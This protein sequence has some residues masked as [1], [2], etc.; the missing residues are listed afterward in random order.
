MSP[1]TCTEFVNSDMCEDT[2]NFGFSL[3]D[4]CVIDTLMKYNNCPELYDTKMFDSILN[5]MYII[6][7]PFCK[8]SYEEHSFF[9]YLANGDVDLDASPGWPFSQ[10]FNTKE[11][12]FSCVEAVNLMQLIPYYEKDYVYTSIPKKEIKSR[13]TTAGKKKPVRQ[14]CGCPVDKLFH[15][16]PMVH[17]FNK[18]IEVKG[19]GLPFFLGTTFRGDDL[20]NYLNLFD[21]FSRGISTDRTAHD[22]TVASDRHRFVCE[23]RKKFLPRS[24]H[25]KLDFFYDR[26]ASKHIIDTDGA[27][28]HVNHGMAS[29]HPCTAHDN[30]I[31]VYADAIYMLR[32]FGF[33]FADI[34][35]NF[36]FA[37][38]GDDCNIFIRDGWQCPITPV[39][40]REWH[41]Q[42][43]IIIK[44]PDEWRPS[45]FL[46]FLSR[47]PLLIG[48]RV[49]VSQERHPKFWA[50]GQLSDF[51]LG[52]LDRFLK[53]VQL[54]NAS[55]GTTTFR[56]FDLLCDHLV[57]RLKPM[58][59]SEARYIA[60]IKMLV[61]EDVVLLAN[62]TR[63]NHGM[64]FLKSR[65]PLNF[66]MNGN[67]EVIIKNAPAKNKKRNNNRRSNRNNQSRRGRGN[68]RG[69]NRQVQRG[70]R[71]QYQKKI[72]SKASNRV[73]GGMEEKAVLAVSRTLNTYFTGGQNKLSLRGRDFL[74]VINGQ[75]SADSITIG[76]TYWLN[77]GNASAFV[78]CA[79][80][81]GNYVR[82]NFKHI[83][84]IYAPSCPSTTTGSVVMYADTDPQEADTNNIAQALN[85]Q[86]VVSGV[87]WAEKGLILDLTPQL[88]K[89]TPK[90]F[91]CKTYSQLQVLD[92]A[93]AWADLRQMIP[94]YVIVGT[95]GAAANNTQFGNLYVEYEFEL[96][97]FLPSV[98]DTALYVMN[99][100]DLSTGIQDSKFVPTA[101]TAN[102]DPINPI[103]GNIEQQFAPVNV[104][105][106][107]GGNT[108][109]NQNGFAVSDNT[110]IRALWKITAGI[111]S[112]EKKFTNGYTIDEWKIV[113]PLLERRKKITE[114]Y[115]DQRNDLELKNPI[116]MRDLPSFSPTYVKVLNGVLVYWDEVLEEWIP[117]PNEDERALVRA[118]FGVGAS[119]DMVFQGVLVDLVSAGISVI[120]DILTNNSAAFVEAADFILD[121]TGVKD[122]FISWYNRFTPSLLNP[123]RSC[124][125]SSTSKDTVN[126]TPSG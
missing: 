15:M 21:G 80:I 30:S 69:S 58:Y 45:F 123:S 125:Y 70:P 116:R 13:V 16:L 33:S 22:S 34:T 5:Y 85:K 40:I 105:N 4:G 119:G 42:M 104:Y 19:L 110:N 38:Y 41:S 103:S 117:V 23:L 102:P 67:Q 20:A 54:R 14:V 57:G 81:A 31:I 72:N 107:S 88:L 37:I 92:T 63:V 7:Y 122:Y 25:E 95:Y 83:R 74:S 99:P 96:E 79:N 11:E 89:A 47:V 9:Y 28:F 55:A 93:S 64:V 126:P 115:W 18:A 121:V 111:T 44:C 26:S 100:V 35:E 43:G 86:I 82:W 90:S 6:L 46:D 59:G 71:R 56:R 36:R 24:L 51:Y 109:T 3:E 48:D 98:D 112:D 120:V 32:Q 113:Q 73:G 29:G 2:G 118:S 68:G 75:A 106:V 78:K 17:G 61:P 10:R 1:Y 66:H 114:Q 124:S 27:I 108:Y 94:A 39:Q 52:P 53:V 77:P 87:P 84:F 50:S 76:A 12:F 8:N 62:S 65:L 97:E 49:A 101:G 91:L 60:G